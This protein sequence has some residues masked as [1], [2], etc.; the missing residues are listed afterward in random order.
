MQKTDKT[1]TLPAT[2]TPLPLGTA[3]KQRLC[4]MLEGTQLFGIL[5][6]PDIEKL[7][8]YAH[9]YGVDTDHVV[10]AEGQQ[11]GFICVIISGRLRVHK[12][13]GRGKST[14][15]AELAAGTSIG[16]MSVIDGLPSSA[17]A[18]AMEPTSLAVFRRSDLLRLIDDHP[19]LGAKLLW[20]LAQLLSQ[21][22]RQTSDKLVGILG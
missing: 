15:L 22:L 16:E 14:T 10:T 13:S 21:R 7:T 6:R 19:Q 1:E 5:P 9:I 4:S 11:L 8:A 20:K 12:D 18:V 17:T 2:F 3:P